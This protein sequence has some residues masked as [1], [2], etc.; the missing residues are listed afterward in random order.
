M[1]LQLKWLSTIILRNKKLIKPALIT[2]AIIVVNVI[3]FSMCNRKHSNEVDRITNNYKSEVEGTN[4]TYRETMDSW[5]AISR[6]QNHRFNR[7]ISEKDSYIDSLIDINS[8]L[9]NN[10]R[11]T[12]E[13]LEYQLEINATFK[14]DSIHYDTVWMEGS[15]DH[16]IERDTAILQTLTIMREKFSYNDYANYTVKYRPTITTFVNEKKDG[17]WKFK[18]I[19]KRRPKY[20]EVSVLTNDSILKPVSVKHY[21]NKKYK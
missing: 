1:I 21:I 10:L 3:I 19:F 2:L 4:V 16:T 5:I 6:S 15:I 20:Y 18:N 12:V 14:G 9:G 13:M 17:K 8:Q 11:K 7:T